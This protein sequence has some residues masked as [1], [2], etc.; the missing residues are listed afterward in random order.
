[1]NGIRSG[2]SRLGVGF[3]VLLLA[4]HLPP[5][6]VLSNIVLLPKVEE[7]PNLTRPLRP[8]TFRQRVIRQPSNLLVTFLHNHHTQH[9]N[10]RTDYAAANGLALA[11]SFTT[12]A[13]AGVSVGEEELDTM[14]EEDTLLHWE[15]LFVISARDTEDV[16]FPFVAD[17]VCGD[18]LRDFLVVEDTT[19]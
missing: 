18:F 5:D 16:S 17:G 2:Y 14:W 15:S 19:D 4:G 6:N 11:L 7:F 12:G 1:M 8:K 3:R 9:S 10:I 13:V